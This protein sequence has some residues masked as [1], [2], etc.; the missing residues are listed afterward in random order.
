M[1]RGVISEVVNL[2]EAAEEG[3]EAAAAAKA[4]APTTTPD[5][6]CSF[7]FLLAE[8]SRLQLGVETNAG[9]YKKNVPPPV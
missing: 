6:G 8:G 5:L 7:R 1:F 3:L 9:A 4:K 2:T